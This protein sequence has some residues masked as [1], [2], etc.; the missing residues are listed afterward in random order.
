MAFSL[1]LTMNSDN[2]LPRVPSNCYPIGYLIWVRGERPSKL[3][4]SPSIHLWIACLGNT[5]INPTAEEISAKCACFII[6]KDDILGATFYGIHTACRHQ[7]S[8]NEKHKVYN[9]H[10]ETTIYEKLE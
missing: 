6:L 7:S 9:V 1:V 8:I 10:V 4:E 3:Q 5:I 2:L